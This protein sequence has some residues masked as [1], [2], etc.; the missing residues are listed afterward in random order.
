MSPMGT[1]NILPPVTTNDNERSLSQEMSR[2]L[3]NYIGLPVA[4]SWPVKLV[5]GEITIKS[6]RKKMNFPDVVLYSDTSRAATSIL[7]MWENKLPDVSIDDET[8][9]KDAHN[10]ARLMRLNSTVTWNFQFCRLWIIDE[11]GDFQCAKSWELDSSFHIGGRADALQFVN[12]HRDDWTKLLLD[13]FETV[14]RYMEEGVVRPREFVF[15]DVESYVSDLVI[16]NVDSVSKSLRD[17][18]KSNVLVEINIENWWKTAK[19][20]FDGEFSKDSFRAYAKCIILNWAI[21]ILFANAIKMIH[22]PAKAVEQITAKTSPK[23]A[24]EL[25]VQ[26]TNSCDFYNAFA[27]H[28]FS[29]CIEGNAWAQICSMNKFLQDSGMTGVSQENL[30]AMLESMVST[31]IRES[32]GQYTTPIQLAKILTRITVTDRTGSCIDPCCGS[33]TIPKAVIDYK[34][35]AGI[36]VSDVYKQIWGSDANSFPLQMATIGLIDYEAINVPLIVFQHNVFDIEPGKSIQITNPADSSKLDCAMPRFDYVL[37]NLPFIDFNTSHEKYANRFDAITQ[38][39]LTDTGVTLSGR[40]DIYVYILIYLWSILNK[41]GTVGVIVSNSWMKAFYTGF[42]EALLSY[43]KIDQLLITSVERFFKNADVVS[44][45]IVLK[46]RDEPLRCRDEAMSETTK[47]ETLRTLLTDI[48]ENDL[49][50]IRASALCGESSKQLRVIKRTQ[51]DVFKAIKGGISFNTLF[52]PIDWQDDCWRSMCPVREYFDTCRGLKSGYDKA[53]YVRDD[54]KIDSEY[55]VP[56]LHTA[57]HVKR[58]LADSD[59]FVVS[60]DKSYD[61]LDRLGHTKTKEWFKYWE[62]GL[63]TNASATANAKANQKKGLPWYTLHNL[64]EKMFDLALPMN[65]STRLFCFRS[66]VRMVPNQRVIP[67]RA[68]PDTDI[69]LCHALLNSLLFTFSTEASGV[70]MGLGALDNNSTTLAK[71]YMPNPALITH[72]ARDNIVEKFHPLL[73]RDINT[74]EIELTLSDRI[75]FEHTVL[76]AYGLDGYYDDIVATIL[77]LQHART[78]GRTSQR[79]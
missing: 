1:D 25:F 20:E 40:S 65:P 76:E 11:Y 24:N 22:F 8:F 27:P 12:I 57:K 73:H 2:I 39:I 13:V 32:I 64:D 63:R 70:P 23:Q 52:Y 69:D 10:K 79:K 38:Q 77:E 54:S 41:G 48:T 66:V 59:M 19:A 55:L 33:G 74:V 3:N 36:T 18:A 21:R 26:I 62:P 16:A 29:D 28:Q 50:A 31:H 15:A 42:Y 56:M 67:L 35:S 9:I 47:F 37:S 17:L 78:T 72:S 14:N 75:A 61:E 68:H 43:Y 5:G 7:Q 30:Q 45:L 60:C 6:N 46:R 49:D 51:A 34:K 4:T 53:F 71:Q 44:N 58:L